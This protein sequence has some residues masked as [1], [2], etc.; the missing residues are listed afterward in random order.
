M[1]QFI[2]TP[3]GVHDRFIEAAGFV[4]LSVEDVTATIV[5]VTK[6]WAEARVK[7]RDALLTIED[8][9]GYDSLQETLTTAHKVASERRLSRFAYSARKP[10]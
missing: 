8:P 9:V 6:N 3:V 10:G 7:H 1:G 4:D 2:F 5:G